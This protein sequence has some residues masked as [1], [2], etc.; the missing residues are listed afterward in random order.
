[1]SGLNQHPAKVSF[2][3]ILRTVGSNPTLTAKKLKAEGSHSATLNPLRR[4]APF[5]VELINYAICIAFFAI[6]RVAFSTK[7][8]ASTFNFASG[9]S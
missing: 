8:R 3:V 6:N 2:V 7:I 9:I 5:N 4:L 1:M